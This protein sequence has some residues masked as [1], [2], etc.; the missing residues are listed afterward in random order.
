MHNLDI[1]IKKDFWDKKGNL[2]LSITDV[3]NTRQFVI[4][5]GGENFAG[6]SVRRWETRIATLNFTYK[7]GNSTPEMNKKPNKPMRGEGGGDMEF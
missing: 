2:A 6:N 5:N 7:I 1:G 3:F 4:E